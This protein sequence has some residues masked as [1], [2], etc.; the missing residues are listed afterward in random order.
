LGVVEVLNPHDRDTFSKRDLELLR[1][2]A[3]LAAAAG[4]GAQAYDRVEKQNRGLREGVNPHTIIGQSKA[5]T[6]ALEL[7]NKV[8]LV[9]T[10]V[11]LYGETGVG[12]ELAARAIHR[13]SPRAEKPFIPINC[14]ALPEALL[15]SELFGHEEGAFTGA[16]GLKLGRFELADSGTLFLD[17]VGELSPAI[18]AKLLRVIQEREF[19][20]VGGAQPITCDVRILAATHCDLKQEMAAGRFREDLYY[21]LCVFPITLPTLRQRIEDIPMLVEHFVEQLAPTLN[22]L[23]PAVTED[24]MRLL[25]AYHWPGNIRELRNVI[26]RALLLNVDGQ[27][28]PEHLPVEINVH[29]GTATT[30]PGATPSD[31]SGISPGSGAEPGSAPSTVSP[32]TSISIPSKLAEHERALILRA[33][34]KADWNQSAAARNLGISRDH[35]R[36]RVKKYRIQPPDRI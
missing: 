33:L 19:V 28:L 15:E 20:R 22:T 34:Q 30:N 23:P 7:C 14:A 36:Y 9:E 8:A 18:Q 16:T 31:A 12:K 2:F 5:I 27:I 1:V 32:E 10:T 35:L 6:R 17:E 25:M 26:E 24:A 13:A 11:L 29:G 3:N 4:A 21:R